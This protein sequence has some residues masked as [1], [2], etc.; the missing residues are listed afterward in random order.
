MY[1]GNL[2]MASD[3]DWRTP[4]FSW[5]WLFPIRWIN[6]DSVGGPDPA[7]GWFLQSSQTVHGVPFP[8]T[9]MEDDE[10]D[11]G[12]VSAPGA[13][14]VFHLDRGAAPQ[15]EGPN[16]GPGMP[17]PQHDE[18]DDDLEFDFGEEEAGAYTRPLLS[19]T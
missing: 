16:A 9:A 1:D 4:I 7:L 13:G 2:A 14:L 19:S 6:S 8:C 5:E 10:C 11:G 15:A 17:F 12:A 18:D 3:E